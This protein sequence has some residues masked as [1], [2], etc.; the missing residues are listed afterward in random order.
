MV[1]KRANKFGSGPP[2]TPLSG[3]ARKKT[4]F[5]AGGVPL[6][7]ESIT[8]NAKVNGWMNVQVLI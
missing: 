6:D 4:Y 7:F 8:Y 2:P 3:N 1:E 5:F